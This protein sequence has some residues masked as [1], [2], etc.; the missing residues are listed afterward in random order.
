MLNKV[1]PVIK[2]KYAA[3]ERGLPIFIQQDN[4]KTHN[5]V[6]SLHLCKLPKLMVGT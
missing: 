5:A 1:L 2:A 6:M 3:D 4:A